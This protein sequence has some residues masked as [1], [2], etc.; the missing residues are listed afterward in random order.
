MNHLEKYNLLSPFQHGFRHRHSTESQ[1]VLTLHDLASSLDRGKQVDMA[2]LDF[3]KAFDKVAHQR[4][5]RK[6]E[7]YGIRGQL[8]AWIRSFL[9][10]RTQSTVVN[11]TQSNVCS[12]LS[13]V[14]QGTVL[15]PLLFLI[16][17]NFCEV[18]ADICKFKAVNNAVREE[19][20]IL[21]MR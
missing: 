16:Y 10:N 5:L 9:T 20:L 3:S 2:L 7:Y 12:V 8:N 19:S 21:V 17:I 18:S 6:L 13:G 15:G 11:G 14:P 4:L 1:L